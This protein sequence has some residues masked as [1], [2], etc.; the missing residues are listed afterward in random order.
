MFLEWRIGGK[1]NSHGKERKT[2]ISQ[3]NNKFGILL[4][5]LIIVML[6]GCSS[7]KEEAVSSLLPESLQACEILSMADVEALIGGAVDEPR[8][9]F[10]EQDSPGFWMSMCNYYSQERQIS[11]GITVKP[12]G[13]RENGRQAFAEY[14]TE[15]ASSLGSD[16]KL[17]SVSGIGDAAGWDAS[18]KQLTVF[19]GPYLVIVGVVSPK[20][21]AH[22]ALNLCKQVCNKFLAKLS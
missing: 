12:H 18:S 16:Y 7:K 14:E 17:E 15:L 2:G 21:D 1:M 11:L 20:L 6:N 8:K 5:L 13:K 4:F 10:K 22:D 9:T 19:K 3:W